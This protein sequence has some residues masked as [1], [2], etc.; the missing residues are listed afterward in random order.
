MP[1]GPLP[2]VDVPADGEEFDS[3]ST[4]AS[5]SRYRATAFSAPYRHAAASSSSTDPKW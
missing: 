5:R 1:P 3:E 2:L 4:A